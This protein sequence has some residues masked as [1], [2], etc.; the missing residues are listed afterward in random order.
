MC[1]SNEKRATMK[2]L[3]SVIMLSYNHERYIEQALNSV[4]AQKTNFEF[5]ILIGDDASTDDSAA[6][7][8]EYAER[9]ARIHLFVREENVGTTKNAYLLMTAAKGKYLA[10]C[11]S[12][13]YWIDENKLQKQVDFLEAHPEFIG[14]CHDILCVDENGEM[15]PT[16]NIYWL[17]Q[18]R[19]FRLKD[20]K[21]IF[22]PG[23]SG[24]NVRRNIFLEPKYD[25][26][27]F[28][29]A[30]RLIGDR[31]STMLFLAQGDFYRMDD[32]MACY[33][34]NFAQ[35]SGNLTNVLYA[36]NTQKVAEELA[37]VRALE[38][39]AEEVL[40]V[41]I[42]ADGYRREMLASMIWKCCLHNNQENRENLKQVCGALKNPVLGV[43]LIP[44]NLA[45]KCFRKYILKNNR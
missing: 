39:Y 10:S 2:P 40:H 44:A 26:S 13:D 8:R 5:E 22:L 32:C 27:I 41:D 4:L 7:L 20:F 28:Y 24:S 36:S 45:V 16:Q 23:H 30:H 37:F 11:E 21:G 1:S 31:T 17:S 34:R 19:V 3:V 15:L 14:C 29:K 25:Y 18:K 9:D 12:D 43:L 38:E 6:V 33:R 35:G 42:R